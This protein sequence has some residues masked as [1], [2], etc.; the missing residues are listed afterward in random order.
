[1]YVHKQKRSLALA[2]KIAKQMP[3]SVRAKF[4]GSK[5]ARFYV[6]RNTMI[7][8]VLVETGFLTNPREEKLLKTNEYRQEL[9]EHLAHII[10]DYVDAD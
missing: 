4:L 8:S 1:M 10:E 5:K 6:L 3:P 9:A 7:P 2:A